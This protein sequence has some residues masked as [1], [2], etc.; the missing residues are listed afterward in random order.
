MTKLRLRY[1]H[2]YR[3]S[4]GKLRHYLRRPGLPRVPLPGLPGSQEFMEAYQ[5]GLANMAP[6]PDVG[7]Q[8]TR[9]GSLS[10]LVVR[11]YRSAEFAG[12]AA[13]TRRTRRAILEAFRRV[14][15]DQLV[16]TLTREKV[17]QVMAN[18]ASTPHAANN[19]LK[20]LRLLMRFAILEGWR[21]DD[22]TLGV[23]SIK[24]RSDGF[25]TWT[26]A[27]IAAFEAAHQ[28]GTRPRLALALLLYT[29]QRRGD[30]V[31]MGR[32]DVRDGRLHVRQS[33]TR[34]RLAIPLHAELRAILDAT[35]SG[36]LTF[37]T[38]A[39]GKP[40][41]AAGFGNWFGDACRTARL[42]RGCSAHGLRKAAARRLAEAGATAH[43]IMAITGHKTL[44]EVARY[45]TAA[46]Q[47]RLADRAMERIAG[48]EA[49]QE[50]ANT[51]TPLAK[52]DRKPLKRKD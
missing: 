32:Q 30:V 46:S 18:R 35:P 52:S 37:L 8:R 5:L 25:H 44:S 10:A 17:R 38:T 7:A 26:E 2:R 29:A 9:P 45:T 23:R 3:D 14:N 15:G 41:T 11:Y 22:P 21:N 34:A 43:E 33:K 49:E 16:A 6:T 31:T 51:G 50:L 19:L 12:L 20:V 1:V 13:T 39:Q 27:E 47:E 36:H 40:F 48:P 24:T 4:R 28:I 42:P